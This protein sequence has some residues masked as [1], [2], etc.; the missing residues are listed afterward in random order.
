M[1]NK[2]LGTAF[3]REFCELLAARG[4][5]VHFMSPSASG[6]QPCDIIACK[7]NTPFLFDCKT[8][9]DDTFRF[10]RLEDNQ[11]FA[12]RKFSQMGNPFI[13]IAVKHLRQIYLIPYSF[14]NTSESVKLEEYLLIE[15]W[16]FVNL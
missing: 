14:F 10:S 9:E 15:N 6:A 3:E 4:F 1:N 2:R 8:C 7:K 11:I 13:F 5:W 16:G 12:F